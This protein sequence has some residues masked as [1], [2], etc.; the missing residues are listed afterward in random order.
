M[1]SGTVTC[2]SVPAA[3]WRKEGQVPQ[4]RVAGT[5]GA[6]PGGGWG[7]CISLQNG[8]SK[9]MIC[10]WSWYQD[11]KMRSHLR[12]KGKLARR[13]QRLRGTSEMSLHVNGA[14]TLPCAMLPAPP[15]TLEIRRADWEVPFYRAG[16]WSQPSSHGWRYQS[17]RL[18]LGFKLMG[19]PSTPPRGSVHGGTVYGFPVS[20]ISAETS[21]LWAWR[22]V[23]PRIWGRSLWGLSRETPWQGHQRALVIFCNSRWVTDHYLLGDL[24]QRICIFSWIKKDFMFQALSCLM[25]LWAMA[26]SHWKM[27]LCVI[28]ILN[29]TAICLTQKLLVTCQFFSCFREMCMKEHST[30]NF[31]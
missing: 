15:P 17:S 4:A 31:K 30:G 13:C 3:F 23:E 25:G 1:V 28:Y 9:L 26:W 16:N 5:W 11:Q 27:S 29:E 8:K 24:C 18:R 19:A 20:P 14:L 22:E 12:G 7:I 10:L 21:L 2:R 6:I